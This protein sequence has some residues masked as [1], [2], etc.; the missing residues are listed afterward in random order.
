M[1][2]MRITSVNRISE[3]TTTWN[4]LRL[5]LPHRFVYNNNTEFFW[6]HQVVTKRSIGLKMED[7]PHNQEILLDGKVA[8]V[9]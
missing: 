2:F 7:I 3:D 6:Q 9:V 8:D 4:E 5:L 1:S